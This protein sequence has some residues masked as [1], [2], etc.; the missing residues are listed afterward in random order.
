LFASMTSE[1]SL[2]WRSIWLG[3]ASGFVSLLAAWP[4]SIRSA[5]DPPR[6]LLAPLLIAASVVIVTAPT[7]TS[8]PTSHFYY[9]ARFA[10]ILHSVQ[11]F[12]LLGAALPASLFWSWT[13]PYV[14]G[15]T[16]SALLQWTVWDGACPVTLTENAARRR[17]GRPV[18]PHGGFIPEVLANIGIHVPGPAVTLVLYVVGF[19]LCGWIG[20]TWVL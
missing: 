10:R 11:G 12:I 13:R 3:G 1:A 20:L 9:S 8:T 15:V 16:L 7:L 4:S 5:G 14:V 18:M 19:S 17:E 6:A 2:N